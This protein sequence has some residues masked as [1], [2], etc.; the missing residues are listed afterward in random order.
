[1]A[2]A[3][4]QTRTLR[5]L[6]ETHALAAALAAVARPGDVVRLLGEIGA[7]KTAFA[8]GFAAAL[9]ITERVTSPTFVLHAQYDEGRL[10]FNHV[11]LY[12]LAEDAEVEALGLTDVLDDG[13]TLIEWAERWPGLAPPYLTIAFAAGAT[14]DE[15]AATLTPSGGDWAARLPR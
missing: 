5:S 4:S 6:A 3:P 8:Q 15:R 1:M 12:R 11:D 13:V 2:E 14:E 7:G 9:G 10:P